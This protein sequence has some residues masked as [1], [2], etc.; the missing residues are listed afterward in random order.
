MSAIQS[1]L[2]ETKTFAERSGLR[3]PHRSHEAEQRPGTCR[4]WRGIGIEHCREL[5]VA[6]TV[7]DKLCRQ[8]CRKYTA[9]GHLT[10]RF[11][12]VPE[13]L[14]RAETGILS[15]FAWLFLSEASFC[16]GELITKP[17]PKKSGRRPSNQKDAV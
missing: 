11:D 2:G 7:D 10:L 15:R 8:R 14:I 16:R 6:R 1:P 12:D 5:T 4:D 9:R 3:A 13:T 17:T